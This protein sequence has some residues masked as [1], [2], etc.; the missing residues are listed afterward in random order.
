MR[1]IIGCG[2]LALVGLLILLILAAIFLAFPFLGKAGRGRLIRGFRLRSV[3]TL[4]S[5]GISLS[6]R[7][8]VRA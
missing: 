2:R 8:S 3:S 7:L 4:R 1:Y 6:K 5:R